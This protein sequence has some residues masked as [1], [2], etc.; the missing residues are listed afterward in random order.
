MGVLSLG[1]RVGEREGQV[2]AERKCPRVGALSLSG[3][4]EFF[5]S[6]GWRVSWLLGNYSQLFDG[7]VGGSSLGVSCTLH[8]HFGCICFICDVLCR[9]QLMLLPAKIRRQLHPSNSKR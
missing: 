1:L 7:L 5:F 3:R 9:Y 6:F 2:R 4:G 8:G